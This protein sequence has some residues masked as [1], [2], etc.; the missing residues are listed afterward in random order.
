MVHCLIKNAQI[1]NEGMIK[2]CDVEILSGRIEKIAADI[3]PK[4]NIEVIDAKGCYLLPGMIDDQVHFREPGL[5][6]KGDLKSESQ[7]AIAGGITSFMDMPNT[8]PAIVTRIALQEKYQMA[9]TRNLNA[10]YG[11]YFGA[12]NDNWEEISQLKV[13]EACGVKVFMGAS[14]GNLLVDKP[15]ALEKIFEYCPLLIATHCEHSPTIQAQEHAFRTLYGEEVPIHFHAD[16]R[17]R[18]ACLLSSTMAVGLARKYQ[19]RLH[20]LHLT[21]QDELSLFEAGPIFNKLITAEV[22]V[23]H[24]IFSR[25][26]YAQKGML[27]KCNPSIKEASDRDALIQAVQND[28][29]DIIATD[30]A[31][32]TLAEKNQSYFK[33]PSGLPLVQHALL[34]L[35]ELYHDQ[36][37]SLEKIVQKTSHAVADRFGIMERGY[38]REGYFAD[39]VLVDLHLSQIIDRETCLS[40]CGWSP[41][42]GKKFRSSILKTWVNGVRV[43]EKGLDNSHCSAGQRLI[44]V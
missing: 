4:N 10:N 18:Q 25:Q 30:H 38:I 41:F 9:A 35:F 23:H 29:I 31:P 1:V 24:L 8:N 43:Y 42:E 26:D 37:L 32:H 13:G 36:K 17:S 16:I 15:E 20:V 2:T 44:F 34:A 22:C 5:T 39:L 28:L 6:H 12:T 33:A 27:I 40:K 11:F 19:K 7:A 3:Q 21:T 14:T